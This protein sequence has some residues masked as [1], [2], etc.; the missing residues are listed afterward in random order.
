MPFRLLE[1]TNRMSAIFKSH[2]AE[3][4]AYSDPVLAI[5]KTHGY[6]NRMNVFTSLA[7]V[8]YEDFSENV[9]RHTRATGSQTRA[10]NEV[11]GAL[12]FDA[13][14]QHKREGDACALRRPLSLSRCGRYAHRASLPSSPSLSP[15]RPQFADQV[16]PTYP[17]SSNPTSPRMASTLVVH[18]A[19]YLW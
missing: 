1:L 7:V 12:P 10:A 2:E 19:G 11:S 14:F 9:N 6:L 17:E 8:D 5:L 3:N 15:S 16:P 13:L 18:I 4:L